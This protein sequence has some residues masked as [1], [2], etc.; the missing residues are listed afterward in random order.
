MKIYR[1]KV[2]FFTFKK[3]VV[4]LK[5][6]AKHVDSFQEEIKIHNSPSTLASRISELK[7]ALEEEKKQCQ[8]V[9]DVVT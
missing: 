4:E 8:E 7:I 3:E 2:F 1:S 9:S 6:R 5:E